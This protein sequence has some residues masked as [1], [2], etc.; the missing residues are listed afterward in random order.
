M[1]NFVSEY[2]S[3][4]TGGWWQIRNT[5]KDHSYLDRFGFEQSVSYD[6]NN[7]AQADE[8]L[9]ARAIKKARVIALDV[10]RRASDIEDAQ[11]ILLFMLE[12]L[13]ERDVVKAFLD[14]FCPDTSKAYLYE[15]L[16]YP[17]ESGCLTC[18][19]DCVWRNKQ[20]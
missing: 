3:D 20:N 6:Y 4:H 13:G 18:S 11:G 17:K 8:V 15:E 12:T 2:A 16:D 7:K 19:K 10:I 9:K 1:S 14:K 5:E